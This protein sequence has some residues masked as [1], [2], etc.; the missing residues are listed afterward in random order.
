MFYIY[1]TDLSDSTI[2]TLFVKNA[3]KRFIRKL[4]PHVSKTVKTNDAP[5]M[6]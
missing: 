4:V 1:S 6:W 2:C 5:F 3:K